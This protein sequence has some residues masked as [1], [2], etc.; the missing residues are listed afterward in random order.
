MGSNK[1][2]A[3]EDLLRAV[4]AF[5]EARHNRAEAARRLGISPSTLYT[6]L[7]I[8]KRDGIKPTVTAPP[9]ERESLKLF[10]E[11]E[12]LDA[13]GN[14]ILIWKKPQGR[15]GSCRKTNQGRCRWPAEA[16][17]GPAKNHSPHQRRSMPIC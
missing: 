5:E 1:P 6:W 14:T 7:G 10:G 2:P 9:P 4:N 11:S 15:R 16:H 3:D 12:L 17:Q 8:A 13:E